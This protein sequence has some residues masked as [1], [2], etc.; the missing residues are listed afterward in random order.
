MEIEDDAPLA[1]GNERVA[2][3]C[4]ERTASGWLDVHDLSTEVGERLAGVR[5]R[6]AVREIEHA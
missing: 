6:R 2:G 1:S 4:S 5:P 3:R